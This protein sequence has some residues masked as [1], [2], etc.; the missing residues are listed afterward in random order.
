MKENLSKPNQHQFI[1]R[2]SMLPTLTT[3]NKLLIGLLSLTHLTAY[4]EQDDA[5]LKSIMLEEVIVTATKTG[6][7]SLQDTPMAITALSSDM[8]D[9]SGI[10][11]VRDI[12]LLVPGM[13]ITANEQF[14][15]PFIR[16]I[17]S[18]QF[19]PGNDSATAVHLDGVY[20]GRPVMLFTDFV[21]MERIEVIRGPNGTLYGRNATAGSI[22]LITQKPTDEFKGKVGLELGNF[23]KRRV[24]GMV[25]G[26]L[27]EGKVAAKVALMHSQD[28]GFVKNRGTRLTPPPPLG[29][30]GRTS[31]PDR[32]AEEDIT[33][34]RVSLR[35]TPSDRLDINLNADYSKIKGPISVLKPFN[36]VLARLFNAQEISDPWTV[37]F[38]VI[39][40]MDHKIWG[41]SI[42]I[43]YELPNGMM[44]NSITSYRESDYFV[45]NEED[46]FELD[47]VDAFLIEDQNQTSQE[48]QLSSNQSEKFSWIGGLF[49]FNEKADHNVIVSVLG[50]DRGDRLDV[51]ETNAYA[52]FF[53]GTYQYS[54]KLSVT[55]GIR[56]SYENKKCGGVRGTTD[57]PEVEEDWSATTPKLGID[58]ALNDDV[59]LYASATRGFKS[60]VCRA[61][62]LVDPELLWS[63]ELG[64]KA[65]WFDGKLRTNGAFFLYDYTDLQVFTFQGSN[66]AAITSAPT[67]DIWGAE[68]EI[69][70]NPIEGLFFSSA[71]S[72]LSTEYSNFFSNDVSGNVT[73]LS[74]N[75]LPFAPELTF[76]L[77]TQYSIPIGSSK[78]LNLQAEYLWTDDVYH[79]QFNDEI[80]TQK[81]YGLVNL[82]ADLKMLDNGWKVSAYV[83]NAT[84][85][86]YFET[87]FQYGFDPN[88][89]LGIVRPPR[90]YGVQIEYDF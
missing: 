51:N 6:A 18:I 38:D 35:L 46:G 75:S 23:N 13:T 9:S 58:Y 56:Q 19:H 50:A 48:F 43:D 52:A 63:Y 34:G 37:D 40:D 59:L 64:A 49:F 3:T 77:T 26:P 54:D 24:K 47:V 66:E 8:L 30:T 80:T 71:I 61:E 25:S 20:L 76:N 72:Y 45:F 7:S 79:T 42:T 74:G 36:G 11:S 82:R 73:D 41:T 31:P 16:G 44:F 53:Q 10:E 28:D 14:A 5:D 81:A 87:L 88:D 78:E 67:V 62:L 4:A 21:D 68:L 57:V 29:D 65:D 70:A 39:P 15:Q 69:S 86:D 84:N 85:E 90:T 22:N 33:T 17:G 2:P 55:A 27:V 32:L 1:K 12:G 60:G 89:V 83:K